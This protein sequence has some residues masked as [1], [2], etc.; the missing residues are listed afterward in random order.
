MK[1]L[2]CP[3]KTHELFYFNF[4]IESDI[5]N[6]HRIELI[7]EIAFFLHRI[8]QRCKSKVILGDFRIADAFLVQKYRPIALQFHKTEVVLLPPEIDKHRVI[9]LYRTAEE[10]TLYECV[11]VVS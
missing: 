7:E 10:C 6:L 8:C 2:F 4:H 3:A 1:V 11:M 9:P 5:V